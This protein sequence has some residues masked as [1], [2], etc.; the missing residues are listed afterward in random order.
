M[1]L[2]ASARQANIMD[3]VRKFFIDNVKRN[4]GIPLG[5]DTT[6]ADPDILRNTT[7]DRWVIVNF[8]TFVPG[9]VCLQL[10][11][12]V[13]AAKHDQ[14]N[15]KVAQVRDTIVSYLNPNGMLG[16]IDLYQS[17]QSEAWTKIGGVL[18][19]I[20]SESGFLLASNDIK[21]KTI[22]VDLKWG[23]IHES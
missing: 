16:T 2:D 4:S 1:P 15:F 18:V 10:L 11:S 21:Y 12:I 7:R 5:F 3:S 23:A 17:S 9:T 14:Q 19:K 13:C 6:I 22:D 8:G 20:V